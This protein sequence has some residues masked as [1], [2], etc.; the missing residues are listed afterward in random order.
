MDHELIVTATV[1]SIEKT[2]IKSNNDNIPSFGEPDTF[3]HFR[4]QKIFKGNQDIKK[5]TIAEESLSS[6]STSYMS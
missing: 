1:D 6:C 2:T 4:V 3:Y 5:F